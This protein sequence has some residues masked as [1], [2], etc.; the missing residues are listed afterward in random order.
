MSKHWKMIW[1]LLK[2]VLGSAIFSLGFD[3]FLAPYN[4]NAG[5]LSGLAQIMVNLTGI[6]TVGVVT[7]IINLPLFV[8]GGK[9]IGKKFFFGSLL[10][11]LSLSGALELFALLPVPAK[12]MQR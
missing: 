12:T 1:W 6:G 5:G 7:A 4:F 8:L 3:L 11:M 9:Q 10:G 2:I